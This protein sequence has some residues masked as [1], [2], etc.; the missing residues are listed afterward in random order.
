MTSLF[1]YLLQ[2]NFIANNNFETTTDSIEQTNRNILLSGYIEKIYDLI[3]KIVSIWDRRL[4]ELADEDSEDEPGFFCRFE[5]IIGDT[6]DI[7]YV[8]EVVSATSYIYDIDDL[9]TKMCFIITQLKTTDKYHI[10]IY[11]NSF[12]FRNNCEKVWD[13]EPLCNLNP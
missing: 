3:D 8:D 9:K 6:T 11:L 4:D 10:P 1:H 2:E 12:D 5:L 7:Y 13:N